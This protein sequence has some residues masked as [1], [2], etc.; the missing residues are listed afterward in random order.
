MKRNNLLLWQT[1]FITSLLTANVVT[2]KVVLLFGKLVVPAA[3]VAYAITFL[4]TDIINE[5]YGV[6][7]AQ[8]IVKFGFVAQ[9]L[10]SVLICLAALLPVA[11]FMPEMQKSFLMVL[12]QN[13]RFVFASLAAYL[14][15]QAHDVYAFNFWKKKTRGRHKWVRNNLST[16]VSQI[17]DTVIFITIAFYGTVPNLMVMIISQYIVKFCLALLDTPFFYYFTRNDIDGKTDKVES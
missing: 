7:K 15:S 11:P 10:A 17:L 4:A 14:V 16:M 3:V 6:K 12:G 1:L 13:A 2:G 8:E 5:L 9:I